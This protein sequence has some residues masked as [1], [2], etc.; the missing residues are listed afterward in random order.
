MHLDIR[1]LNNK[2][3]KLESLLEVEKL[4]VKN[5]TEKWFKEIKSIKI[6]GN[7]MVVLQIKERKQC[8]SRHWKVESTKFICVNGINKKD[9]L[10]I[11]GEYKSPNGDITLFLNILEKVTKLMH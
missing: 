3:I 1:S 6:P 10:I 7:R 4:Y 8:M 5:L 2:Y 11:I 9:V